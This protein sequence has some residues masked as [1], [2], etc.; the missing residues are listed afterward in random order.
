MGCSGGD[1]M[2]GDGENWGDWSD[3]EV[4]PPDSAVC[5]INTMGR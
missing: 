1:L 2:F 3:W 4:C 5:G